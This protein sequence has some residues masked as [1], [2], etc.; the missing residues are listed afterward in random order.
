MHEVH[1]HRIRLELNDRREAA[2]EEMVCAY[3]QFKLVYIGRPMSKL[4]RRQPDFRVDSN[5]VSLVRSGLC[6]FKPD[7]LVLWPSWRV[8]KQTL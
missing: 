5:S 1:D 7:V 3:N 2:R 8:T 6:T 4:R